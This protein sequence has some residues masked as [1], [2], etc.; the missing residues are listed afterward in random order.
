MMLN[1]G[2]GYLYVGVTTGEL[3]RI[4]PETGQ[5]EYLGKPLP[6]IRL[7]A[8]QIGPDG[9]I[10]GIIGFLGNC[11]LF[12][13]DRTNRSFEDYGLIK[14]SKTGTPIFIAHD[15]CFT[16]DGQRIFVGE[17]DTSDRTGYLWEIQL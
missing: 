4:L 10:W 12:A 7:P 3:V 9:R 5:V 13:Y 14:D 11:H 6:E 17:R 15:M 8:M 16:P 1:G 2:D